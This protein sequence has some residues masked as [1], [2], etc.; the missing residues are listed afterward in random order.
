M[1]LEFHPLA[2]L[3]PLIEGEDFRDLC[4][5]M[6]AHGFRSGEEIVLFEGKILD[7]RNRYRAAVATGIIA[8]DADPKQGWHFCEFSTEGV[9]GLFTQ[10]EIDAGPLAFVIAKNL[11]RRHMD[12]SQRAMV[13]AKLASLTR[14]RPG[15]NPSI[16]GISAEAGAKLL[17]VSE[18]SIERARIVQR[19]GVPELQQAVERGDITVAAA[20][21]VARQPEEVQRRTVE[22]GGPEFMKEV[23]RMREE[24]TAQKKARRQDL[25]RRL[26]EKQRAFPD[27]KYGVIY[28]DPA[29]KLIAWSDE[30][31]MD[32]AAE[33]HYTTMTIDELFALPVG[34]LAARDCVLF[35]WVTNPFLDVGMELLKH[36]GFVYKSNYAWGKDK[37]G[38]GRWNREKHEL[39]LIGVKGHV[40]CPAPGE[41]WDSLITA[42][43]GE[44]SEKPECV[45]EMIEQY[46]PTLPKIELNRRGEPR[47]GW[48]AWGNE[49]ELPPHDPETGEI[50]EPEVLTV[51]PP[52]KFYSVPGDDDLGI[53]AWLDRSK[54]VDGRPP[55]PS[56][57][58]IM[59]IEEAA[60]G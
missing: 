49:A 58:A 8:E 31:G 20:A 11:H 39:L 45:A 4:E 47:P 30:T 54:W 3:F 52:C 19:E 14:G 15:N 44:H 60:H 23:R 13:A 16:E 5:G 50:I 2:N 21:E 1:M 18:S 55:A 57:P 41:Q 38:P 35:M 43:R 53:P 36:R 28:E 22:I 59:S 48:D 7:G 33:N 40:P 56:A 29:W 37:I 9:D 42:P 34:D 46:F 24:R 25:E 12:E 26:G 6:K 27:K 10:A 51:S 32:R 17:N